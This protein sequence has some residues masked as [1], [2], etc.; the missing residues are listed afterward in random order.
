MSGVS[1]AF[2]ALNIPRRYTSPPSK[3][4]GDLNA[5]LLDARVEIRERPRMLRICAVLG[6]DSTQ[7]RLAQLAWFVYAS[8]T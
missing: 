7:T 5:F 3:F 6:G 1:D 8:L 2:G 4:Q